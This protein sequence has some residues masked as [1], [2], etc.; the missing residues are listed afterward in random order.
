MSQTINKTSEGQLFFDMP[1][2]S[3]C[4]SCGLCCTHFRVSF[5]M[6]EIADQG[7]TINVPIH[8]VEKLNDFRAVMKGT[9][10]KNGRCIA[11]QGECGKEGVSCKIYANRPSVCRE[12][13][14][15]NEQG[16]VNPTCNQLRLANGLPLI[17][18]LG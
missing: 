15:W 9:T 4:S 7:S 17:K 16:K 13:F 8:M 2:S 6:G 5:P 18:D 3:P 14:V 1:T 10:Q 11:L 12:F